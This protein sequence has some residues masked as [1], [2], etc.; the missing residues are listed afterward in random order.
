MKDPRDRRVKRPHFKP[1]PKPKRGVG[2]LWDVK[3]RYMA[4]MV[5]SGFA[6]ETRH[7]ANATQL[8]LISFLEHLGVRRIVD[9][10][11]ETLRDYSLW[12]RQRRDPR[13]PNKGLSVK[14]IYHRL[15]GVKKFFRQLTRQGTILC[16]P[17]EDLELPK[18]PQV[19]PRTIL[20]AAETKRLL[21][22]PDVLTLVGYRD[23]AVLE[24]LYSTAIR[25]SELR[26]LKITDVDFENRLLNIIQG[27][28]GKD[29]IMPLPPVAAGY[30][31]EYLGKIRPK[32]A[33]QWRKDDK[34]T[35]F[36]NHTGAPLSAH[37]IG[38]ILYSAR[39]K[40]GIDKPVTAMTMRHSIA[41]HLLENGM[42][43]RAIQEFMGHDKLGTTEVYAR[44]TLSGLRKHF[45]RYHPRER[46]KAA[47]VSQ[48]V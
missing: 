32:L 26:K 1:G 25:T 13:M 21:Q 37:Q 10:A 2:E 42:D 18:T 23:R 12:L 27:K 48:P 28:G 35:F 16:D 45:N 40:A 5:A 41:T 14:H 29:R 20:T 44:V 30:L 31:R 17:A 36:L 15:I 34:G 4:W 6:A 43:I 46:R 19:L 39:R 33:E 11:P 7:G 3:D 8:S 9:V 38:E 47:L 24:T 22:A